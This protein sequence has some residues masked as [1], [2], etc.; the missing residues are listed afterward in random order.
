MLVFPEIV[1]RE[2]MLILQVFLQFLFERGNRGTRFYLYWDFVPRLC[3]TIEKNSFWRILSFALECLGQ[4]NFLL[5]SLI[6]GT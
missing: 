2:G 5:N 1:L 4:G 6:F 3:T